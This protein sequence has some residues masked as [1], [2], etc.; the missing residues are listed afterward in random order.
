MTP[1]SVNW[2]KGSLLQRIEPVIK[3]YAWG[4]REALAR[5]AGRNVPADGPE[6]EL[7]V[8]AHESGPAL[9]DLD[10]ETCGLDSH[11]AAEQDETLGRRSREAFGDRL[12]FLLK[13]LAAEKAL[14][15]QA[16]PDASRAAA[17]PEGTYGDTWAKPEAWVPLSECEAYAG[18]LPFDELRALS[19]ELDVNAL[20]RMVESAAESP[21]P[22]HAV[23]A[24]VLRM[25]EQEQGSFVRDVVTA[26]RSRVAALA[27]VSQDDER[28]RTLNAVLRVHEQFPGDIGVVVLLTMRHHVMTPGCNY[29]IGAGV[30]HSFVR[31]TTIEV[32][33][34]SDNVVRGGLTPKA[35]NVE[36]LLTIVD[37]ETQVSAVEPR[38]VDSHAAGAGRTLYHPTEAPHFELFEVHPSATPTVLPISGAPA[39]MV[40]LDA[41]VRVT[42]DADDVELGRLECAWSSACDGEVSVTGAEGSRL[43]VATVAL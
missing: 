4:S 17:A 15:I 20:S 10:G 19:A 6:A 33:A 38:P 30:L 34:N 36:E 8:G 9:L 35:M 13:I 18:S 29:F 21:R 2:T 24:A 31:G 7:W 39:V 16:H 37:V 5:L 28:V 26:V 23:L 40:A 11:I 41:P 3:D 12:P 32:L 42:C 25:P 27:S 43:F 1:P 14:S 22:E